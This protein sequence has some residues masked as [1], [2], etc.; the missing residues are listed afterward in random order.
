MSN[1]P[2]ATIAEGGGAVRS[3]DMF[4]SFRAELWE[5]DEYVI[6]CK[7]G[8][9]G[10]TIDKRTAQWLPAWLNSAMAEAMTKL[11][12]IAIGQTEETNSK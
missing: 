12:N 4:G 7:A 11:P 9:I 5:A 10:H 3:S 2:D 1:K 6:T 8:V